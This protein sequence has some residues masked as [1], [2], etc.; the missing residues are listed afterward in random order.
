MKQEQA[1]TRIRELEEELGNSRQQV[2]ILTQ[3]VE[4]L[5]QQRAILTQQ[6]DYL[7][8]QLF[9]RKSE[10][11]EH[12]DLFAAQAAEQPAGSA[13]DNE[14]EEKAPAK[15][16]KKRAVREQALPE[17]L[18]VILNEIIPQV[19][20]DNPEDWRRIGQEESTQVERQPGY[21][22][23]RRTVRPKYV[24]IENP[25]R[26]P[27]IAPAAPTLVEGG[28]WGPG[29][30][31]EILTNRYL[32]HLPYYRQE[33][34][35]LRRFG[36]HLSRKTM[37]DYA[38]KVAEQLS[39]LVRR[40]KEKIIYENYVRADE[41]YV[42]FLDRQ[43]PKGSALGYLW[44]YR[45]I[46]GDVI[47]DW[48]TS[49]EHRH[50]PEWLGWEYEGV[51]QSDG[52]EAY[53]SY[54]RV[55]LRRGKQVRH[56]ACLAHIR[57]KFEAAQEERPEVV[58]WVLRIMRLLYDLETPMREY[59][60]NAQTRARVRQNQSRWLIDLLEKAFKS[61][62]GKQILPKSSL[63]K[64]L[65]YALGQWPGMR[66]YLEEGQVN[67]DNN[68]LENDIR[69]T[70]VG[71]KNW[72]FIGSAEA[73]HRTAILYSLLISARNYGVDPHAYLQDVITKLPGRNSDD[74]DDL[75]P[76]DWAAANRQRYPLAVPP[77]CMA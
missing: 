47:F 37:S 69:P 66:V 57:R 12:P 11:F 1:Q 60:A 30:I 40:M 28:F 39:I 45:G 6:L 75:L 44:A 32:D 43:A 27:V 24:S 67:I 62:Q 3:H 46:G 4:V 34:R 5:T 21:L 29:L 52:Y 25:L 61:L 53:S 17:N 8:R 35:Y 50:L 31:A 26:P 65:Q 16:R 49:R 55:Q 22:Y 14:P 10:G 33:T 74:I 7:K 54:C 56:A 15:R 58:G 77:R 19:V 13:E 48:Q 38:G 41:T 42:R 70:A 51:L 63:G 9:G 68:V 23:L 73:G 59:G 72:L 76:E 2:A 36:V 64:A 18:P 20:Q 71:K